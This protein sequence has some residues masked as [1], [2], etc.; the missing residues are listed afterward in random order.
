M[1][2]HW[3][4][5][6]T[7]PH[8]NDRDK[9]SVLQHFGDPEDIYFA[10]PESFASVEDM[11]QTIAEAL[12]DK[13]L[14]E[15]GEILRT[16]MEQGIHIC[17]FHDGAYPGRLKNIADPPMVLYYKG[18]LPDLD[19][20]PVIAVVGTRKAS[21][22]GLNVS[23]RMGGQLAR[24]G[25]I[26]V[27]GM[28]AG[29]DGSAIAG[30]LTAGGSAVGVLGCGVDICY[31]REN[32]V[33]MKRIIENGCVLSEYPPGTK[34][35]PY[36]F[37]ARNRIIAGLSKIV[38]VVEAGRKSGT[39]ITAD[40]ALESGREVFVVPGNVTSPYSEGTNDLIKQG[41]PIITEGKDI[42]EELGI[43]YQEREKVVFS[44]QKFEQTSPEEKE[45]LE[46]IGTAEPTSA[47]ILCRKLHKDIQEIQYILSLLELS[48][49]IKHVPQ[50]GYIR[51]S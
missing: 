30:A 7:R 3:I 50:A 19:G 1:L 44:I 18:H 34:A 17:T 21:V 41:C 22:Y 49:Y 51:V 42:L 43:L 15:A 32:E 33:L 8:M 35:I 14:H 36:Y 12:Q 10:D 45:V 38:V 16:C 23:K 31:P 28:A 48:G 40:L 4:W 9:L 39:F 27:S 47:E 46:W 26:V 11:T 2:I 29:I 37:P 20:S 6:A 24:C 13:D 5:L 25:G